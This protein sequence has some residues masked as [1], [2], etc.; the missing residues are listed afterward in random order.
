MRFHIAAVAVAGPEAWFNAPA[1]YQD[2]PVRF[3]QSVPILAGGHAHYSGPVS[4]SDRLL[5]GTSVIPAEDYAAIRAVR[6][7]AETLWEFSDGTYA[8]RVRIGVW[9]LSPLGSGVY[10]LSFG[11]A[12]IRRLN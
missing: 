1:D 9:T 2:N 8:Y 6:D 5:S 4:E 3:A 11:L 12:V 10:S 7:S